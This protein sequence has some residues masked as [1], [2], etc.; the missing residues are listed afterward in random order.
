MAPKR[1]ANDRTGQV[2]KPVDAKAETPKI[3]N[4]VVLILIAPW[5][6]DISEIL[7]A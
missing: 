1:I 7:L 2:N 6:N 5:S 3:T 4:W